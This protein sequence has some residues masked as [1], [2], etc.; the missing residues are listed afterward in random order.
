MQMVI[1]WKHRPFVGEYTTIV[2][3]ETSGTRPWRRP[4]SA[5]D[6]PRCLINS[7]EWSVATLRP[8]ETLQ[9]SEIRE[10]LLY[11]DCWPFNRQR[12][13]VGV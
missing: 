9:V 12:G 11:V 4:S 13:I 1:L 5:G 2:A 10:V 6:A 7:S 3:H 8:C